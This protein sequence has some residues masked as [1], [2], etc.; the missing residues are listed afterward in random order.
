M[1]YDPMLSHSFADQCSHDLETI[2]SYVL[3]KMAVEV[4][5]VAL[6]EIRLSL[7]MVTC[8]REQVK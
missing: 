4:H 8:K 5:G 6:Q 3:H 1:T 7:R 2:A